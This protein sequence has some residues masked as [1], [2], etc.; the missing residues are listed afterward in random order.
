MN[1]NTK[2]INSPH[3]IL[4]QGRSQ[5]SV[6]G[7]KDIENFDDELVVLCTEEGEMVISGHGFHIN[8]IDLDSGNFTLDG[9]IVSIS[10]NNN[11]S[12]KGGFFSKIF[13]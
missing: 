5:L 4:M 7:V 9:D 10:Y 2:K 3:S 8:K 6:T 13:R 12:F 1:D 11:P